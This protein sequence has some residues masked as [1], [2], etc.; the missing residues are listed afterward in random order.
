MTTTAGEYFLCV[1]D[2]HN[3]GPIMTPAAIL[4]TRANLLTVP[5]QPSPVTVL[6]LGIYKLSSEL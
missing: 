4:V 1:Q 3:L 6:L 5:A 2:C